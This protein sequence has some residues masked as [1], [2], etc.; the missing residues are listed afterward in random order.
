MA[1]VVSLKQFEGPLDLLLHLISRAKVDIKDIFVSEI[2]EQYLASLQGLD[3][4]DMDVASEFLTMA[5]TLLEIKSR[6]LLPRPPQPEDED[7]ETPEQ[8][9]IRRLEE[10]K[11]YKESAGRMKEFEQAAMKVF[12]KLPEEYPLPPQPVELTGLSLDGLVRA[13]ERILARQAQVDEPGRVFRAITRDRFT[14]EQCVLNLTA[15][16]RKGPVLFTDMLSPEVTRD[17]IVTYFMAMLELLKLGRLR[18]RQ[19]HAYDDILILPG[20]G[21]GEDGKQRESDE[22][23]SDGREPDEH[24]ADARDAD[25]PAGDAGA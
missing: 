7:G 3:E 15:R 6:A 14:I 2:T 21:D 5:A 9:L 18:A 22:E 25:A 10:Y 17:E 11:L 24:D 13:M 19:E 4:L 16:L 20:K 8:A 12:S 1:Y 23:G